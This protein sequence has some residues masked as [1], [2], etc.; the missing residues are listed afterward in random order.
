MNT[1][2][3]FQQAFAATVLACLLAAFLGATTVASGATTATVVLRNKTFRCDSY[4]QP[5]R[6]TL[7]KVTM[8]RRSGG[9]RSA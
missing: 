4:S 6:L 5:L 1:G 2:S 9:D 7:L 3:P 8:R